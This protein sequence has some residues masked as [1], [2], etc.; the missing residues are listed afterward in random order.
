MEIDGGRSA[1]KLPVVA[2]RPARDVMTA[3]DTNVNRQ[4]G[5]GSIGIDINDVDNGTIAF[6]NTKVDGMN[7]T[8]TAGVHIVGSNA[9]ITFDKRLLDTGMAGGSAI[10][11]DGGLGGHDYLLAAPSPVRLPETLR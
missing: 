10:V 1:C 9:G 3:N 5:A 11:V 2:Q 6:N 8:A 4:T 7:T